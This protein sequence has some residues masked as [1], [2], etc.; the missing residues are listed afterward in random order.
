MFSLLITTAIA[1]S[2]PITVVLKDSKNVEVG[3]AVL[4]SV[5]EGVKIGLEVKNLT[6][7]EHAIHFHEKGSC[8]GPKFDS[9]GAHYS[10]D[11][12][13]HGLENPKGAHAGDMANIKAG[14]DGVVKT[15]IINKGVTLG[16]GAKSLQKAGGTALVIHEKA[17]DHKTHPS[18][19]SGDRI[20]CGEIKAL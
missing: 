2:A 5:S 14:T 3:K 1:A 20:V 9:A 11:A 8:V 19:N 6:P 4:T 18:G 16:K 10:P 17:D 13:E 12:K 15:E 7:G